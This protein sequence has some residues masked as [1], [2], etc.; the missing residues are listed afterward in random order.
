MVTPQRVHSSG[1][2][3]FRIDV[4]ATTVEGEFIIFEVQ[5]QP[6]KLMIER[7]L[8]YT[9][10]K[11]VFISKRGEKL[12]DATRRLPKVIALN[13][14]DYQLLEYLVVTKKV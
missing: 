8:L 7:I 6:F 10:A 14:L 12:A 3:G 11:F 1:D 9:Q 2:R 5:L 4:E 13:I